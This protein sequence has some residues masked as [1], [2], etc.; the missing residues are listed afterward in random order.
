MPINTV[1]NP[2][3]EMFGWKTI[4]QEKRGSFKLTIHKNIAIGVGLSKGYPLYCYVAKDPEERP[5]FVVYLD[6]KP[7]EVLWTK[8]Q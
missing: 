5:V 2:K 3:L 6:G 7:R 8:L 1:I 4:A